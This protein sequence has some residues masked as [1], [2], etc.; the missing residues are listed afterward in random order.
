MAN[1]GSVDVALAQIDA[2]DLGTFEVGACDREHRVAAV[3]SDRTLDDPSAEQ[4]QHSAGAGADV[5]HR[6]VRRLTA[7]FEDRLLD[8]RVGCVQ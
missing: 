7:I 2:T 3:E 8:D 6:R 5:E 1:G 4:L